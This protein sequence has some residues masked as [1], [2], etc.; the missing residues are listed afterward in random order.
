MDSRPAP[1]HRFERNLECL[2]SDQMLCYCRSNRDW[3]SGQFSSAEWLSAE[4]SL[5]VMSPG[6][7]CCM[8]EGGS[9]S[10]LA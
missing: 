5:R 1:A 10:A 8:F 6:S 4:D 2:D 3:G 7:S 9:H